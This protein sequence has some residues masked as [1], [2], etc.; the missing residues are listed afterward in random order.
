MNRP[1]TLVP[2]A[3]ILLTGCGPSPYSPVRG[4]VQYPGGTPATDLAGGQVVFEAN[5][6]DGRA[7]TATGVIGP[8]GRFQL[9]AV[10][11]GDGTVPGPNRC[12]VTNPP[13]PAEGPARRAIDAKYESFDTSGLSF[14]VTTGA[15]EF[16]VV[17][18]RA[19][20]R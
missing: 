8:D 13:A 12:L 14:D 3:L 18:E 7:V 10:T 5:G 16:T 4:V 15:N 2:L 1:R 17:V 19:A 20:G 11:P 9:T 6:P